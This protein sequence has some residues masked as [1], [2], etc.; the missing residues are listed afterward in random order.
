MIHK[1]RGSVVESIHRGDAVVVDAQGSILAVCGDHN[2]YTYFRSSAKPI[3]AMNVVLSGA[4]EKFA[5]TPRE[6]AL[7]CSSHYSEDYHISAVRRIL[8]KIGLDEQALQCGIARS[9]REEIA[10]EQAAQGIVPQR[11]KSDCS[12]KHSGM[13]A[14]C[15]CKGYPI[16][17]YLDPAHPLQLEILALIS[18][19]CDYPSDHISVGIDGC[20]VPVFAL[21]IYNMALAFTRL[22]QPSL[23]PTALEE[24]A[25]KVFM[26]MVS[27]P[28]MVSGS[29]G[30]C[31]ALMQ[32]T[33]GRMIGKVGAQGV[34]CIGIK[35][36]ALGIA[37][38]IEDGAIGMATV[39]AMHILH[40][41]NLL[42]SKEYDAL[43]FFHRPP[44]L[45]DDKHQIGEI[46][47]VFEL[48]TPCK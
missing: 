25:K 12:G 27:Y 32:A 15:L 33:H 31:T 8:G 23:L 5:L 13:L 39:S 17:N 40:Q 19:V 43:H 2:K 11:I 4:Y 20:N 14:T 36:P 45:N 1:I 3:Q 9:I 38:K 42:S 16:Q 24:A 48:T 26:A 37:L 47:P 18:S 10:Y 7:I 46:L 30:F 35:D 41:M 44:N 21:P 22:A 28:E 6:L 29:G 34:Y